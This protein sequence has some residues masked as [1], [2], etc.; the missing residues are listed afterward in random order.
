MP[1]AFDQLRADFTAMATR[2]NLAEQLYISAVFHKAFVK[3]DEKGTEAAAATAVTMLV[4]SLS[5]PVPS[6]RRTIR[7]CSS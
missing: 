7:S 6:S 2:A 4:G 5:R 1:S 3:V